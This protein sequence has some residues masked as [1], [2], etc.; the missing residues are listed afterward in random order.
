MD[1]PTAEKLVA[2]LAQLDAR[3]NEVIAIVETIGDPVEKKELRHP[4]GE[5]MCCSFDVLWPVI[6]Q[7]RDL[8]PDKDTEWYKELRA[9]R[10]ARSGPTESDA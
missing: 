9:K 7:Y 1:R 6:Q 5:M 10:A 2:A 3:M 4:L 8:D